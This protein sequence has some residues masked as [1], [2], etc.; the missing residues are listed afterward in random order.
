MVTI[1][2]TIAASAEQAERAIPKEAFK[3]A[4]KYQRG[5]LIVKGKKRKVYALRFYENVLLP[6][7]SL[8]RARRSKILGAVSDI[9]TKRKAWELAETILQQV[10]LGMERPQTTLSFGQFA[11]QWEEKILPLKKQSTQEFYRETLARHLMPAFSEALLCDI[12]PADVQGFITAQAQRF[13]WGTVQHMKIALNQVLNQAVEW[14]YLREN[15]AS[16]V[17]MPKPPRRGE[18]FI[19][20]PEQLR[21]LLTKLEEPY[22]TLVATAAATGVRRCELFGLR[23]CDVDFDKSMIYVRQRFY[24]GYVDTPKTPRSTRDLPIP[25]WLVE[26]LRRHQTRT[27][28]TAS[29]YVFEGRFGKPLSATTVSRNVLR[30]ALKALGLP[31]VSWH[32]FRRT[33]ATWLSEQGVQIKATQDLLG[34]ASVNTTLEF[35]VQSLAGTRRQAIEQVGRLLDPNGPQ[36][37]DPVSSTIQ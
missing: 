29:S 5:S 2:S 30:P 22:Q 32:C 23:W 37:T 34:H 7:H 4:R 20:T 18:K 25:R 14:G 26:K 8:G 16:R 6:D 15:P 9:G 31:E 17:K 21:D 24:R 36:F 13:A 27:K 33:L 11:K 35:Y 10:N 19:L 3:V 28:G 12:K 1:S